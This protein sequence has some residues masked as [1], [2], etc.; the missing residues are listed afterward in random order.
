MANRIDLTLGRLRSLKQPALAPFVTIGF[1][2]VEASRAL[3]ME[4][5]ASGADMLELGIPFSDPL[6][7]GTTIQKTS[8]RALENKVNVGV[9][10][11]L[12]ASL[13][14]D[15]VEAPLIFMGYYN[16]FLRYGAERFAEDAA[17]AGVDGVIVPDLPTEEAGPFKT[18]C[19]ARDVY[20]IPMLAP[21]S[22]DR[23]IAQ[24]CKDA[25]GFIYCVS[26]AGVT[27]ARRS[28][29]SGIEGLVARV[30]AHTNL[31]II[32][33]FGVSRREH[34]ET[35]RRFADGVAVGSA[36]LD[37][38]DKAPRENMLKAA[39]EFVTGLKPRRLPPDT[40]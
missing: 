19:E 20:F 33:G 21:T 36:L 18:L 5:L 32:V 15:G 24:A 40:G 4:V 1:P 7:E 17:N 2:D 11:E 6:A 8:F 37:V 28:L 3:A 13:R 29:S 35:I 9:S 31:P 34:V 27:G 10:L 25:N 23:R 16:P 30:R 14:G 39:R 26:L 38:V 22:P 12:V